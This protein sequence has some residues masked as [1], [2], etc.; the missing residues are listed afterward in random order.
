[1]AERVYEQLAKT[2]EEQ[3]RRL[4]ELKPTGKETDRFDLG[5][6]V[7]CVGSAIDDIESVREHHAAQ[8]RREAEK[9]ANAAASG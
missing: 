1:M 7:W 4:R 5:R 2:L 6:Q 3:V 9:A 8:A